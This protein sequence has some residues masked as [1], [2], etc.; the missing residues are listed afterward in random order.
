H[1]LFIIQPISRISSIPRASA[2][3]HIRRGTRMTATKPSK[4]TIVSH[5]QWIAARTNL[6]EQEK[7]FTRARDELA[8]L[9][10]ALPWERGEK[11]HVFE[12]PDGKETLADLF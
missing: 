5:N 10:R 9:R 3:S 8:R 6:L 4:H 7:E 2:R 1:G 11:S 12:G